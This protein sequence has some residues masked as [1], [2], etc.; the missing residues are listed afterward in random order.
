MFYLWVFSFVSV[1]LLFV[2]D[3]GCDVF[4][5]VIICRLFS[6]VCGTGTSCCGCYSCY[7]TACYYVCCLVD[8]FMLFIAL[9]CCSCSCLIYDFLGDVSADFVHV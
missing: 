6:G 4:S 7:P 1:C 3:V 2:F 5:F 8:G 9:S